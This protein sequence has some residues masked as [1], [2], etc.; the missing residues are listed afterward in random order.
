MAMFTRRAL[1]RA[2]NGSRTYAS[3]SKRK[4]WI[5]VLNS[6]GSVKY[7]PTEWE[8]V[9][10]QSL[11][12]FG[13]VTHELDH[14]GQTKPDVQFQSPSLTFVADI[15]T[16]S[17]R[18]LHERNPI[19]LLE[20]KLRERWLQSGITEGGFAFHASTRLHTGKGSKSPNV[21]PPVEE[22]DSLIFNDRFGQFIRDVRVAPSEQR[23][24]NIQWAPSS[25]IQITYVPGRKFVWCTGYTSYT[26]PT[27]R[28]RNP[29]YLV[30]SC[31]N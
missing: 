16:I 29:L 19:R 8:I 2:I 31:R 7:I 21:V 24:L 13:P 4:E 10:L 28:D 6:P 3:S 20:E 23:Q 26:V 9:L 30:S 18:G 5:G 27:Q 17:D 12:Q 22:L 15:A 25:V 14:G 11:S 1:Q